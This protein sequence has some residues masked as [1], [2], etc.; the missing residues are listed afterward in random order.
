VNDISGGDYDEKMLVLAA[1][2]IKRIRGG[3][4]TRFL[5]CHRPFE[6][7]L[8]VDA[9]ARWLFPFS[10]RQTH[11]L[12]DSKTMRSKE[13]THY[14]DLARFF[15]SPRYVTLRDSDVHDSLQRRVSLCLSLHFSELSPQALAAEKAGINRWV[16]LLQIAGINLIVRTL[17]WILGLA[18]LFR[19]IRMYR[20]S[21]IE[22]ALHWFVS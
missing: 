14:N 16:V 9:Y 8:R 13:N 3:E 19:L 21:Q 11:V 2:R 5:G 17:S 4:E 15:C 10:T 6:C 1:D 22:R 20:T 7:A 18:F 12:G